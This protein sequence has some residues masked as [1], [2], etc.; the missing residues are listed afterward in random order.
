LLARIRDLNQCNEVLLSRVNQLEEALERSQQAL[1]QEVAQSQRQTAAEKLATA[2]TRSV[3]QLLSELEQANTALERQT[4]LSETLQAQLET[5]QD[6]SQQLERECAVLRKRQAEKT[7]LVQEL[8]ETC[9]DLRSRLQRQQRYTLQ[10][11]AA[12][13]KALDTAA[14]N[15]ATPPPQG[16]EADE[17]P[18]LEAAVMSNPL[19]M[20]RSE[21]IQPWSA[22]EAM[23]AADPQLLSLV[24]SRPAPESDTS[25]P[26][27]EPLPPQS[28]E[29]PAPTADNP[30]LATADNP[31][32]EAAEQQLWQDVERVIEN[33]APAPTAPPNSAPVVAISGED[34]TSEVQFTEPIPWGAPLPKVSEV[35]TATPDAQPAAAEAEVGA[36]SADTPTMPIAASRPPEVP[37][38]YRKTSLAAE[39]LPSIPALEAMNTSPSSPSPVVHPLRPAARK[40]KS[41]SAVELP[42]FPPLPKTPN[43]N[44]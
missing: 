44:A 32:G 40:R 3:A 15:R 18:P 1:Q 43:S 29:P 39:S 34:A 25:I 36:A 37:A 27:V 14:L 11:K 28:M 6:R 35:N 8:E 24:R 16:T 10:F 31:T 41:L 17:L 4:I 38:E 19:V 12:L 42:S 2:Q 21:R 26:E 5:Y 7:H 22:K 9:A 20:P 23:M 30:A 13:E 33:A